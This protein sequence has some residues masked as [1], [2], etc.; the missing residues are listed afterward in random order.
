MVYKN[1][2]NINKFINERPGI[3]I[4]EQQSFLITLKYL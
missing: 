2:K 3:G 1:A 4:E